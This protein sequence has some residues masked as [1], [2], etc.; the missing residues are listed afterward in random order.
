[1][2]GF[3]R[4]KQGLVPPRSRTWRGRYR[5]QI[6]NLGDERI[7]GVISADR[8]PTTEHGIINAIPAPQIYHQYLKS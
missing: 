6:A 5:H 4:R 2:S 3:M 7:R 1:M 8:P